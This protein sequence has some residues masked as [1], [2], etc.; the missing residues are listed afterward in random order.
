MCKEG[1]FRVHKFISNRKEVIEAIPAED[2]AKDIKDLDLE[3]EELPSERVLRIE[4]CM[5]NNAFQFRITLKDKPFTRR[6]ILS[7]VS[8]I[9]DPLGF[10]AP[11][12]LQGK[13]ILQELCKE[14]VEWT[15]QFLKS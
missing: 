12:L 15:T 8:S 4:W 9:Y 10:A 5:E 14:K 7:T 13:K 2:R 3:H 1:G 6:G 11:F